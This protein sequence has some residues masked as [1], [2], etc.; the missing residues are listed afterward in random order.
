VRWLPAVGQ[1]VIALC[2]R[3]NDAATRA[4]LMQLDHQTSTQALASERAFLTILDGSCR[5]PIGGHARIEADRLVFRGII[6]RPDGRD[7]H[8]VTRRGA[9]ADAARLGRDAGEELAARG[10]ADFFAVA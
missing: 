7:A 9:P 2:A 1:G 4:L 3:E 8:E 10:G 6:V 5:T